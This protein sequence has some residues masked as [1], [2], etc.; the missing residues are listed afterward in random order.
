MPE[1]V[2]MT[3]LE[4]KIKFD[5]DILDTRNK[6]LSWYEDDVCSECW[7]NGLTGPI[8]FCS[9]CGNKV[10]VIQ[11][12]RKWS[13]TGLTKGH[14]WWKMYEYVLLQKST[15]RLC[16]CCESPLTE[17]TCNNKECGHYNDLFED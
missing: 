11:V 17:N 8:D 13:R 4:S 14:L 10:K 6:I 9:G 16:E 1:I 12:A 7:D 15:E 3:N 2:I 5:W